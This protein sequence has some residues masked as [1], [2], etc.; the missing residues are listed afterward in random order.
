MP[1]EFDNLSENEKLK[2]DN[3]FLKMKRML[4]NGAKFGKELGEAVS[5]GI[6]NEFLQYIKAF[7]KQA[8]NPVYLKLYDKIGRPTHFK[9]VSAITDE[10]IEPACEKLSDYMQHYGV[11]LGVCSPNIS[12][13]GLYRFTTEELFEQDVNDM[14]VPGMMTCF[15][16][17][18]FYPDPYFDNTQAATEDCIKC[19]LQKMPMGWAPHFR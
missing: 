2:A 12:V 15:T 17:D 16:Y 6:E 9:P 13:R 7:E 4:E 1:E 19:I 3:E 14:H 18:E 11:H 8:A 10:D 5:P